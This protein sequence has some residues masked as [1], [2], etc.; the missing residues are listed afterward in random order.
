MAIAKIAESNAD[1][2]YRL[3]AILGS[4]TSSDTDPGAGTTKSTVPS[5]HFN[6]SQ[7]RYVYAHPFIQLETGQILG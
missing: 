1:A 7:P 3:L 4:C 6:V 2:H 5:L